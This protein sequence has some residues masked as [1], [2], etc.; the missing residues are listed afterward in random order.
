MQEG[1]P[2]LQGM[3]FAVEISWSWC[4]RAGRKKRSIEACLERERLV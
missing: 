1:G 4:Q 3:E 2:G